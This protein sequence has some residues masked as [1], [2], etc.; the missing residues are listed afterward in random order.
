MDSQVRNPGSIGK[1]FAT[2]MIKEFAESEGQSHQMNDSL[3]SVSAARSPTL[4]VWGN[5]ALEHEEIATSGAENDAASVISV[6]Q[7]S[8]VHSRINRQIGLTPSSRLAFQ[9]S[10]ILN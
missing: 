6:A 10:G 4:G 7:H 3:A 1:D 8:G 5:N 2:A 9:C